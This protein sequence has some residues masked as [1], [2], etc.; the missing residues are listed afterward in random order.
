[1]KVGIGVDKRIGYRNILYLIK[2]GVL[3]L[4][5]EWNLAFEVGLENWK[6]SGKENISSGIHL[7]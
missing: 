2:T 5:T 6:L 3:T 1:M 7:W 4:Q